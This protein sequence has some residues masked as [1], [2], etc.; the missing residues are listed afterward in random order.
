MGVILDAMF[1]VRGKNKSSESVRPQGFAE[2]GEMRF[3]SGGKGVTAK[4]WKSESPTTDSGP[5]NC[6]EV[7]SRTCRDGVG[8]EC[9]CEAGGGKKRC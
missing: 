1:C 5:K 2:S 4:V 8:Q 3:D 7:Q 6:S 9:W